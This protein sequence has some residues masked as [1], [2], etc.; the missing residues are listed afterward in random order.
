MI[1]LGIDP[2]SRITGYGIIKSTQGKL[3]YLGSGCIHT[4]GGTMASRLK[5]IYLGVTTLVEQFKPDV[6]A[7]EESTIYRKAF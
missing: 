5:T 2:G 1:I 3:S 7:I 6:M 4:G